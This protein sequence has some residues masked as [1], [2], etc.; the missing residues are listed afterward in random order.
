M[1]IESG[2]DLI[3]ALLCSPGKSGKS[4]E[5]VRGIT[6]LEKL[7]FLLMREGGFEDKTGGELS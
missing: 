7:L 2:A 6:R 1:S 4:G 3:I 5:E